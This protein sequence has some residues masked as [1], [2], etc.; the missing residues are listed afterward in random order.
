MD[1]SS[2][3][4]PSRTGPVQQPER[5]W[6]L[7]LTVPLAALASA[8]PLFMSWINLC[9]ISGCSGGGYGVS[10]GPEPISWLLNALIGVFFGLAVGLLPWGRPRPRLIAGAVIAV[11]VLVALTGLM[12]V[13]KY[14]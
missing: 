13:E 11:V 2:Q 14:S 6:W 7:L 4:R 1:S 12:L 9:G 10:Y 5:L 3:G 8:V